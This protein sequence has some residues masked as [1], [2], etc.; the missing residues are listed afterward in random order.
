MGPI[1]LTYNA[2]P[3]RL[4]ASLGRPTARAQIPPEELGD[5]DDAFAVLMSCSDVSWAD[6]NAAFSPARLW[7]YTLETALRMALAA[8]R[9]FLHD[10]TACLRVSSSLAD[11]PCGLALYQVSVR[12]LAALMR[13]WLSGACSPPVS[14]SASTNSAFT[15]IFAGFFPTVGRHSAVA[16]F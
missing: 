6:D 7:P 2:T 4:A 5:L 12:N 8:Y 3:I 1:R 14:S 15:H 13:R 11:S 9:E 10:W 16:L